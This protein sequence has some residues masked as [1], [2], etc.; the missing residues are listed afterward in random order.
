VNNKEKAIKLLS[1]TGHFQ[2]DCHHFIAQKEAEKENCKMNS[3]LV[4][5]N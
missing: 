3:F 2:D 1:C 5:F 4:E